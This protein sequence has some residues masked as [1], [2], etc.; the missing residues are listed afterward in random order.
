MSSSSLKLQPLNSGNRTGVANLLFT[1]HM[2]SVPATFNHLKLRPAALLLW[3]AISTAILKY[4]GTYLRNYNEVLTILAGSIMLAHGV[5]FLILLYEASTQAPGP[6]VA[7]K[8]ELFVNQDQ[9]QQQKDIAESSSTDVN[10]QTAKKRTSESVIPPPAPAATQI[11]A[12]KDNRF[13]VLEKEGEPIGCIGAVIDKSRGEARL[14][15]WA[16]S[17]KHRRNGGGT[18][19]LK[20]MMDQLSGKGGVGNKKESGVK[21][22]TVRVALQG[23]QVPALRLFHKFGFR[24]LDRIPEML[25]EKVILEI[26]TKEWIA[27]NTK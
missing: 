16:I 22:Q 25:G 23:Y 17:E 9:V 12:N 7:G 3:T 21:V 11:S 15:S 14:V 27:N 2:R 10:S 19:I 8:L 1:T 6:D 24:Q 5:L 4:R 20:T 13:L 26:T 18:L